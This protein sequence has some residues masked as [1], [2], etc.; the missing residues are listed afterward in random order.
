MYRAARAAKVRPAM[1]ATPA[2]RPFMLSSRLKAF[3]IPTIQ[4]SVIG[5]SNQGD[6]RKLILVPLWMTK[7]AR[8]PWK[9]I[10][11]HQR[12]PSAWGSTSSWIPRRRINPPATRMVA[13]ALS[14]GPA[15]RTPAACA[16]AMANPP[17]RGVG[18]R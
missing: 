7:V 18:W 9:I 4:S 14:T 5:M 13:G 17:R 11:I 6:C 10:R 12:T 15:A 3:V 1:A 2:D 8:M 16:M